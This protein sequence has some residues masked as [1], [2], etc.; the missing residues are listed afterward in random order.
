MAYTYGATRTQMSPAARAQIGRL[1]R[2]R[3]ELADQLDDATAEN[4]RLSQDLATLRHVSSAIIADL[5]R[6]IRRVQQQA[7]TV[8]GPPPKKEPQEVIDQRLHDLWEATRPK[9]RAA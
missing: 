7:Q 3:R 1:D 5:N 4:A 8:T 2:Q 6:Q 9:R